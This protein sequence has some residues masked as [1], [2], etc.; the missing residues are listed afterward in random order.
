MLLNKPAITSTTSISTKVKPEA[1]RGQRPDTVNRSHR[2]IVLTPHIFC[3]D[4]LNDPGKSNTLLRRQITDIRIKI[5]AAA[6]TIR[7]Q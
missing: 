5:I 7:P 2:R 6:L 4:F 1:C 3:P